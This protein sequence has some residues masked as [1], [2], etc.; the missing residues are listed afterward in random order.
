MQKT[1]GEKEMEKYFNEISVGFSLIGGFI[2][3]FLGRWDML[4]KAIVI[5]VVLDYVT[6][7]LKAIY[8]KSL[9]SEIGFKGLIRKIII[10]VVIATAYV[11]QGIVGDAIPLR[12]ITIL[13]FIANESL[14][15]LENAGEFVPIPDKL[16]DTLI[17]L[18]DN[19]GVK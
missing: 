13:F 16:K 2:C 18:R 11:I 4:L 14:S 15:L 3:K 1:K 7:L 17:Q 8:N 9:S 12:E 19:K 6:G 10:F 5:L